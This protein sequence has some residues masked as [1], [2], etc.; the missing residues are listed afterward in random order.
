M[1]LP[2][3]AARA[4]LAA[5][6]SPLFPISTSHQFSDFN[7]QEFLMQYPSHPE[8]KRP[9][10]LPSISPEELREIATLIDILD[11][12]QPDASYPPISV[13][14]LRLHLACASLA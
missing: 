8:P 13:E 9:M 2:K 10:N 11:L 6:I 14:P 1:V 12:F 4:L 3:K 7:D 5:E